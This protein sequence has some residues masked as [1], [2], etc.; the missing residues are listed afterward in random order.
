MTISEW[1]IKSGLPQKEAA[2][3]LFF[4]ISPKTNLDANSWAVANG[5]HLIPNPNLE[6]LNKLAA[7]RRANEPIQYILGFTEFCGLKLKVNPNVL[8]PRQETE[9][10]VELVKSHILT[11]VPAKSLS[12]SN[13]SLSETNTGIRAGLDPQSKF[14]DDSLKSPYEL[15]ATSYKLSLADI[16]TGSGAIALAL[17]VWA[18]ENNIDLDITATDI[19]EKALSV[20]KSNTSSDLTPSP[21]SK[22]RVVGDRV[23]SKTFSIE[24]K[25]GSLLEPIASTVDIIVS[26][27]PYIPSCWLEQIDKSVK[28]YEPEIALDGGQSGLELIDQLVG[29]AESKLNP[30]GKIFLEIWQDHTLKDFEKFKKFETQIIKDAFGKN[31][32]AILS[33]K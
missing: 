27:L 7:L 33:K 26:N 10:L 19:S 11:V 32:F 12:V 16:G 31:R 29:Q 23:R 21:S 14:G 4:V 18:K 30:H 13:T 6:K 5:H 3:L 9:E 8:I 28:D 20:A 25:A 15:P 24:F 2:T 22:E 1:I 17:A